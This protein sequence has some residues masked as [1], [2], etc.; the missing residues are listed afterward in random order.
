MA[1]SI[2]KEALYPVRPITDLRD[3]L[4]QSEEKYADKDAYLTKDPIAARKIELRSEAHL[5]LK[6]SPDRPYLGITYRQVAQDVRAFGT[7]LLDLDEVG[8][9]VA[10]LGE[11]R[12][13]WYVS[14]LA[15][16]NGFGIAVP[17]DKEQ[18]EAELV[19]LLNRSESKI[20]VYSKTKRSV[21]E[22]IREQIP[23]VKH[24]ICMDLPKEESQDRYFWDLLVEGQSK[25]D[26]GDERYINLPLDAQ[27]MRILLFTS[28]TTAQSKAVMLSHR[29]LCSNLMSMCQMVHI[30]EDDTFLS[31]LPIH[32]TYECTCG[33][34]CPLYRG[35]TVAICEGLR[36]LLQNIKEARPT[37][38]LMVP[39]MLEAIHR[40][41]MKKI[42]ADPKVEK[43]FRFGMKL[44]RGLRKVGIDVRKK[45]FAQIHETFGGRLGLVISGGAA[46]EPSMLAD[47]R[48]LGINAIQ[49]YGV[50]ECSPILAVNRD[51]YSKDY[52]AGLTVPGV[53][54][55][56]V[57][58]DEQGIGEIVGRGDNVMLG[59]YQNE[60]LTAEV[61]DNEGFYHTGDMGY[62]DEKGFVVITG[63]KSNLIV[64]KN[65]KN[66]FPEELEFLIGV[67]ERVQE[68]VV[69][70]DSSR[71]DDIEVC[72][73]I[74][75]NLE[76]FK[77][78]AGELL[79]QEQIEEQLQQHVQQCNERLVHY[80]RVRHVSFRDIEFEKTSSKKIRRS[81]VIR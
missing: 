33:F 17:L 38:M 69:Y 32:H 7:A 4:A 14:Y 81:S 45:L 58:A 37:I 60:A 64:T 48:D 59:Y 53:E 80:K 9:R 75:P 24:F 35:C 20:L 31:V 71:G 44:S 3:L 26:A 43:K 40:Q 29:N 10:I 52:S 77:N 67:D 42:K 19:S 62:L 8:S 72:C 13:E 27:E 61:I 78:E 63:R 57:N 74:F 54:L 65:G 12:Y 22:S 51:C 36:Y 66:I 47:Y 23:H 68:V 11:T 28:G 46:V 21:I 70:G 76:A 6:L 50:T 5:G 30:G 2:Y 25:L 34:L 18:P 41:I 49:G 16:V 79:P 56:I 55:K 39:L 73:Q 15:V 1:Q